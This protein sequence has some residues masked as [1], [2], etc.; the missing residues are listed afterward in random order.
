MPFTSRSWVQI[1]ASFDNF[2]RLARQIKSDGWN[3]KTCFGGEINIVDKK[4]LI[5]G[6]L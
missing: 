2:A 3:G 5:L 1:T 4:Y 6:A